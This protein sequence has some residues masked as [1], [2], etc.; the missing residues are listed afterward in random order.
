[1]ADITK[2]KMG[3]CD[4]V[5]DDVNLGYTKGGVKVAYSFDV[6][7][8]TVDQETLPIDEMVTKQT[9]E[10]TV[11][12]AE[13][14][15]AKLVKFFPGAILMG[16]NNGTNPTRLKL[17]LSSAYGQSLRTL[18]RK[19]EIKPLGGT[20]NDWI[21]VYAAVPKPNLDLTY[22]SEGVRVYNVVFKAMPLGDYFVT[23]GDTLLVPTTPGFAQIDASSE[24][25]DSAWYNE[26]ELP[27][28]ANFTA[29]VDGT[30]PKKYTFTYIPSASAGEAESFIWDFGDGQISTSSTGPVLH[31][32]AATGNYT[33][34]LIVSNESGSSTRARTVKVS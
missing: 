8:K 12:M 5:F 19:L 2:V 16:N 10:A 24:M 4:V 14:N 7:E 11:P 23:F 21:T 3:A 26:P 31:T 30:D 27:P 13:S 33:A 25:L 20:P 18:A 17:M 15:L 34:K 22:E 28:V 1:M 9:F 6:F 32:Y 29:V